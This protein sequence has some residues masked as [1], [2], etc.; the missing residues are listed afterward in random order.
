MSLC[1]YYMLNCNYVG[2]VTMLDCIS[3]VNRVNLK[4]KFLVLGYILVFN[5]KQRYREIKRN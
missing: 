3:R 1:C 2:I 4:E 5:V